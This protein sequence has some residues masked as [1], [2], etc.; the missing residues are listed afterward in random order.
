[1]PRTAGSRQATVATWLRSA[2]YSTSL[3]GKYMN[4]YSRGA[5]DADV[6]PGWDDWFG[7]MSGLEV[8]D[9]RFLNYWVRDNGNVMRFGTPPKRG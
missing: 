2:G 6:P 7:H 8:E 5:D 4:D 9:G 1:M 3:V